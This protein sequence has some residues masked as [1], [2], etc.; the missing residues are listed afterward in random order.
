V[1]DGWRVASVV[2]GDTVHVSRKGRDLTLRLIGIDT[3]ETVDPTAPVACYGPQASAFAKRRL[4]GRAVTLELDRS[5][6]R[7]DRYGRTLAYLWVGQGPRRWLYNLQA[8]RRGYAVEYTYDQP[9]AW[10]GTFRRAQSQ[11]AAA[12]VGLWSPRTCDGDIHQPAAG[13]GG[14]R[15]GRGGRRCARGYQPCLP[16]RRDLDCSQINGPVRVTGAD[17]Y[18]LD[19]DG[20]GVACES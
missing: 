6:G 5:Q 3:P 9:Y 1:S 15:P 19:S 17:Q 12:R 18:H 2:D 4:T 20:D 11:A 8:I 14:S 10:R 13:G 16:V 7:L